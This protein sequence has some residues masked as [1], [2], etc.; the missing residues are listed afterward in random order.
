MMELPTL[1]REIRL[2]ERLKGLPSPE[3]F[4]L[5]QAAMPVA[6]PGEVL[7][8]NHYFLVSASLRA[9]ISEGAED[10]P[11]VPFPALNAGDVLRAEALGEVLAAPAGSNLSPGDWVTHFMGW[12][13]YAAVPLAQCERVGAPM[14]EPVGRL[15][16]LGHGWTAYAALTRGVQ[17]RPGDTVFVSSAAGAIGSMAG[18]IARKLGAKRVIGSTST[19]EKGRRLISELGYDAAVTRCEGS[20]LADQLLDASQGGIDVFIDMV[21]GETLQASLAA[22]REGARFLSIGTLSGQLAATG[23]GRV[24][25][26]ELDG[27]Q[28][29][30]KR[31]TMRGYSA[32][33]NPEAREEWLQR[34]PE[35]LSAGDITFPFTM[36]DG[37][38]RATEALRDTAKGRYLGMVIVKL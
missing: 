11:G 23:T 4:E 24:A 29:L 16:Y 34:L 30:L 25:P 7:V 2:I 18:Q 13:D 37:L 10:V 3:H 17:I 32:D 35:W 1:Q 31:I 9:M 38:E 8:R 6:N 19:Q 22:A 5:A 15:G 14:P 12:R 28:F 21:G 27:L 26:V 20:A 33:D 36:I